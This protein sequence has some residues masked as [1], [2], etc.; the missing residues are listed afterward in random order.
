MAHLTEGFWGAFQVTQR[1]TVVAEAAAGPAAHTTS[2]RLDTCFQ[3]ASISKQFVAAS[4]MLLSERGVLSLDDPIR[5]WWPSTPKSW[6][7]ITV[8]Q[9]LTHSSGLMHW[10]DI[11]GL[12]ISR[13][14]S[15]RDILAEAI[16][17]PLLSAPGTR[18]AYSGVGFLL[19]AAIVE[20]ASGRPYG[21]FVTDNIFSPLGMTSTTSG[22]TPDGRR[23]A[24]G[25]R[26]GQPVPLV[27]GLTTW[28]GT[29]DLW[30]TVADLIRYAD[31][32]RAGDLLS[33]RSQRLMA[34]PHIMIQDSPPNGGAISPVAYGYG[35][36][37]GTIAGH[38]ARFHPGD[39]PGFRSLLA[40]LP[41]A[42][43]TLA[44]LSNEESTTLDEIVPR[45][46]GT[47]TR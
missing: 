18:W 13:P 45:F 43:I 7:R 44:V 36:F 38:P 15:P 2:A 39:N 11:P 21:E 16:T 24:K 14:P 37:T 12:D 19:A 17:L 27:A 42:D 22:Q 20:A 28:P 1:G 46:L 25:H 40:W 23:V 10:G 5:R 29:G 31:A 9:L 34:H 8:E 26:D 30:T 6:D 3:A 41:E 32:V 47:I 4:L 33:D 35:I